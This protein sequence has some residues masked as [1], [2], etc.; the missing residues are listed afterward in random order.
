MNAGA[1]RSRVEQQP[2][3]GRAALPLDLRE[4]AKIK[5]AQ[6]APTG[7]CPSLGSPP[8]PSP[9]RGAEVSMSVFLNS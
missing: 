2:T 4:G 9:R 3:A 8:H 6:E 1:Q 7:A 5:S